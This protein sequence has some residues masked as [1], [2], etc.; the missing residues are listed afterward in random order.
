[1]NNKPHQ[2]TI[3]TFTLGKKWSLPQ[4][5]LDIKS[6]TTNV[7]FA[8]PFPA[9]CINLANVTLQKHFAQ[10]ETWDLQTSQPENTLIFHTCSR[11]HVVTNWHFPLSNKTWEASNSQRHTKLNAPIIPSPIW[12]LKLRWR[13]AGECYSWLSPPMDASGCRVLEKWF[14]NKNWKSEGNTFYQK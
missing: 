14:W 2:T 1:M 11:R 10:I 7:K 4:K 3:L 12:P 5:L 8:Q 13:R 9:S 6:T